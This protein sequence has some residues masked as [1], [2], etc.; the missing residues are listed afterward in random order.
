M[1]K[2]KINRKQSESEEQRQKKSV[3]QINL[4]DLISLQ[5]KVYAHQAFGDVI[6]TFEKILITSEKHSNLSECRSARSC[7]LL[8][9]PS[10]RQV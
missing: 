9:Q 10:M 2:L 7:Y 8:A 1:E 5:C 3:I 4:Y 6:C